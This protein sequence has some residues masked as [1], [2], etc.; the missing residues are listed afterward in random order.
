MQEPNIPPLFQT[1]PKAESPLSFLETRHPPGP[2]PIR[3]VYRKEEETRVLWRVGGIVAGSVYPPCRGNALRAPLSLR[4]HR[5]VHSGGRR[6]TRP[7]AGGGTIITR[8][9]LLYCAIHSLP[10][11]LPY[12]ST[13]AGE[14]SSADHGNV[15]S[16][17]GLSILPLPCPRFPHACESGFPPFAPV[18]G[19]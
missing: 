15:G 18:G 4:H 9:R 1:M 16:Q 12:F 8:L 7:A 3:P 17:A 13:R 19:T 14:N 5:V 6:T 2:F 10:T 11:Y